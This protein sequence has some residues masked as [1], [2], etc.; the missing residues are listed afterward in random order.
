MCNAPRAPSLTPAAAAA[1]L[2][3]AEPGCSIASSLKIEKTARKTISPAA[4]TV[5]AISSRVLPL[6]CAATGLRRSR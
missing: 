4:A 1:G 3:T 6:I 5:H 2:A